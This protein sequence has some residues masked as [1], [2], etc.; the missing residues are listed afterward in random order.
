MKANLLH[1]ICHFPSIIQELEP[2][3]SQYIPFYLYL[4]LNQPKMRVLVI[5]TLQ[6]S[7]YHHTT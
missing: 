1:Y 5:M 7:R 6:L 2:L 4:T 3:Y